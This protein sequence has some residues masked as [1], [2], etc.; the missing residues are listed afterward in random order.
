MDKDV[1]IKLEKE[2]DSILKDPKWVE[3][4][5]SSALRAQGIEPNLETILSFIT[6]LLV[7]IADGVY[8]LKF[9]RSMNSD[10]IV[11]LVELL[12]R[13]AFEIRQAFISTRIER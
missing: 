6:G 13:R 1:R 7:G 9:S 5:F 8:F 11:E 4:T 12:K 2:V 3:E 10:E